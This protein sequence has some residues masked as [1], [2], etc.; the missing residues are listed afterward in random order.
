M[1][2]FPWCES[3]K[4]L[5]SRLQ[6]VVGQCPGFQFLTTGLGL[7]LL[8]R[9]SLC[10]LSRFLKMLVFGRRKR[11]TAYGEWGVVTGATDGIG[12]AL[13]FEMASKGMKIFLISRSPDRL[14]QVAEE[15]RA[16][17]PGCTVKTLAVDFSQGTTE[18]LYKTIETALKNIDVGVLINNVG[19]SYPHAMYYNELDL[20][21][22][23]DLITVNV[24][25]VLVTS[26]VVYPG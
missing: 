23:D 3:F 6:S 20:K 12:K 14:Q 26:R 18:E 21:T 8:L 13:A 25:S 4:F 22:L 2:A 24:R 11:L 16:T 7:L 15:L 9:C 19:L 10:L 1:G 5:N 17:F